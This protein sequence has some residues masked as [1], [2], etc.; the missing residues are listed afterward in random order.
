LSIIDAEPTYTR[1]RAAELADAVTNWAASLERAV[2]RADAAALRELFLEDSFLRDCGALTFDWR[3]FWGRD[4]VTDLLM[5]LDA[6]RPRNLRLAPAWP[7]PSRGSAPE[8]VSEEIPE[9]ITAFLDFDTAWGSGVLVLEAVSD[10]GAEHG[11]LAR[12]VVT[13]LEDVAGAPRDA[14]PLAHTPPGG[15]DQWAGFRA[16]KRGHHDTDPDVLIVGAGHSG[17]MMAAYLD[18]IGVSALVVDRERRLG[19]NWR[20]RYATLTLH[21]PTGHNVFPYLPFPPHFPEYLPKDVF[22]DWIELY[23]RYLDLNVWTGTELVRAEFDEQARTWEATLSTADGPRV[24]RPRHIVEATGVTGGKPRIPALP[25]MD[26]F[27]GTVLHSHHFTGV[28]DHPGISSAIVVGVGASGHDISLALARRGVEVALV[29]RSPLV[30]VNLPTANLSYGDEYFDGI[31]PYQLPDLA[32][33]TGAIHPLRVQ[34]MRRYQEQIRTLDGELLTGLERAGMRLW[35]GTDGGG[36]LSEFLHASGGYYINVGGSDA[37]VDGRIRLVQ[38]GAISGFRSEGALL[39]DG[40]IVAA[41]LVVLATGYENRV[42]DVETRYGRDVAGRLGPIAK[43]DDEGE[44]TNV[45]RPTAQRGLWFSGG[46][47]AQVRRSARVLAL[48][49][50]AELAGLVPDEVYRSPRVAG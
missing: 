41:D 35:D 29:Q 13:R 17:L 21:N 39:D 33:A 24:L 32:R 23:A 50:K 44:W 8:E 14:D 1:L 5:G 7:A 10:P 46:G 22:A 47:I 34:A 3:Q 25:G 27:S 37:V 18:N 49:I 12:I 16:H 11:L 30:V 28:D 36:W 40:S 2:A 38:A 4:A 19:D 20:N 43:V 26:T 42:V 31:T 9:E 6:S 45:F 48:L 15:G